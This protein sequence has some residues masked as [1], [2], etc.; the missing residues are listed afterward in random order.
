MSSS[1][2]PKQ[3][4]IDALVG[5]FRLNGNLDRAFDNL[6]ARRLGVNL[7]DLQCLSVVQSRGG[8]T[9]GELA[10]EAGLT[11]GAITGVIDRLERIGYAERRRD[12]DDRRRVTITVTPKF[13]EAADA[14][15][16]PVKADWDVDLAARFTGAQLDVVLDFLAAANDLARRHLA[17]LSED[18]V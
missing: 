7:T 2:T 6:A 13:Y 18:D 14:I 15:W 4:K 17:R 1:R 3:T 8:V 16:R 11:S 5:A 12:P 10:T 9:A